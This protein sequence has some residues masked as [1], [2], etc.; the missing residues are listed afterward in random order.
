[1]DAGFMVANSKQ[2]SIRDQPVGFDHP[3]HYVTVDSA[4]ILATFRKETSDP[5][6]FNSPNCRR[7][8]ILRFLMFDGGINRY[9]A[10][11]SA[12]SSV[13]RENIG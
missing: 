2:L 1:M 6:M 5:G 9:C 8:S 10:L 13:V 3:L 4:L 12:L 7:M 11:S